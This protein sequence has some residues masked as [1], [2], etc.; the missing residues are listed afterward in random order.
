MSIILIMPDR[1]RQNRLL[2]TAI[3]GALGFL[4]NNQHLVRLGNVPLM[5]GGILYLTVALLLGPLYGGTAA[6]LGT[7]P[8]V[9]LWHKPYLLIILTL[10]AVVVGALVRWRWRPVLADAVYWAII[11]VPVMTG[12]LFLTQRTANQPIW[13]VITNLPLNGLATVLL[14][15]AIAGISVLRRWTRRVSQGPGPRSLRV[16]LAHAFLLVAIVPAFVLNLV[17]DRIYGD[18]YDKVERERMHET[19]VAIRQNVDDYVSRHKLAL[20][21]LSQAITLNGSFESVALNRWVATWHE[22]YPGFK[23]VTL[24]DRSGTSVAQH[25]IYNPVPNGPKLLIKDRTYFQATISSGQPQVSEVIWGRVAKQPVV[26]LTSPV[27]GKDG[28]LWGVLIGSLKLDEFGYFGRNYQSLSSAAIVIVDG[29]DQVVYS[30]QPALFKSM[31]SLRGTPLVR[32][33]AEN[34]RT[35]FIESASPGDSHALS[36]AS[37]A[38]CATVPWKV[39]LEEPLSALHVQS[40]R[41]YELTLACLLAAIAVSLLLVRSVGTTVTRPLEHL[42]S[43]VRSFEMGDSNRLFQ[44][45]G[46]ESVPT[47]VAQLIED[48]EGMSSRLNQSYVELQRA[49]A[50]RES[51]NVQLQEVLKNL[52][53][54][55]QERTAQLSEAKAKAEEASRSKSLFL[56][57][58]SHEIRTPMTGVLGMTELVLNTQLEAEQRKHLQLAHASAESLLTL[59]NDILDFSKI[60][61]GRLE[62]ESICFS[63]RE[64]VTGTVHTVDFLARQKG[65]DLSLAIAPHIPDKLIGD[66]HRLRQ[67]LLNL[68][69]NAIKFTAS[70]F[71]RVEIAEVGARDGV[72]VLRFAVADSGIGI[73]EGEQRLILEP[74][75]QADQSVARC[76]GGTGLGLTICSSIVA[77]WGGRLSIQSEVGKGSTFVFEV[78]F[79][80]VDSRIQPDAEPGQG[81]HE[82]HTARPAET[83]RYRVLVAE[84]NRVNQLLVDRL[85][86][87][88]NHEVT[89]VSNGREA[90]EA[91]ETSTFD[92]V[93][94]DV[95]MPEVDGF[96]ANWVSP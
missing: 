21:S 44:P 13:V 37:L 20:L 61:A 40:D 96:E 15:D 46:A 59:L 48:F 24:A 72:P 92:V 28:R 2:F 50:G 90:L 58:M 22:S 8:A 88:E 91:L 56:A 10:E 17:S 39:F 34:E 47:E 69:N 77:L 57:N 54:K 51:A 76:Y 38:V 27:T 14:A 18:K 23:T 80:T 83:T 33:A 95:Q 60:E 43:R 74:F 53:A 55:V 3:A 35:S 87:R 1:G 85:L 41:Y 86:R 7:L 32:N 36:L 81:V 26:T 29:G 68:T 70:G 75:R 16:Q 25:P 78:P 93:L 62:F 65:L 19:A 52:D 67:V 84:D 30:N 42:V 9:S 71:V 82:P 94:M 45:D 63:L 11:G 89:M 31:Q 64:C 66:P 12:F 49:L 4:V 73:P 5:L 6:L 79:R